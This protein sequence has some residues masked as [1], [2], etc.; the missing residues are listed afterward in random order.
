MDPALRCHFSQRALL[1]WW[2]TSRNPVSRPHAEHPDD[3][4][5]KTS[6]GSFEL[7][8]VNLIN[9]GREARESVSSAPNPEF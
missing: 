3:A 1:L 8:L 6:V 4:F 2:T 5:R 9:H 7:V